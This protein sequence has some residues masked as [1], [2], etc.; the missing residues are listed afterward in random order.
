MTLVIEYVHE[1]H[2]RGY[3]F[4]SPTDG[5][6][7]A[8]LKQVWRGAMPRGQGWGAEGLAGAHALK[9]FVLDDGRVALSRVTVTDQADDAGRRGCESMLPAV[10]AGVVFADES[11]QDY[12]GD[13]FD[14]G[15]R[16]QPGHPNP[17][18]L[19]FRSW[20][21]AT[22]GPFALFMVGELPPR[23]ATASPEATAESP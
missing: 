20:D 5:Y 21:G 10:G 7:D 14:A 2:Q 15:V 16:L 19:E 3:N 23:D 6:T 11:P 12:V 4:T 1:G 22:R 18:T 17:L 8:A 13:R 9:S